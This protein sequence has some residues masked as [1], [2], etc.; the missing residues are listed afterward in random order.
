MTGRVDVRQWGP[1][2]YAVYITD[3]WSHRLGDF[4]GLVDGT[5]QDAQAYGEET[6]RQRRQQRGKAVGDE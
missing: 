3:P 4:C 1:A 2:C 5:R 6:L